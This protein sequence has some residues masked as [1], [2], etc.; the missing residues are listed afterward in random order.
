MIWSNHVCCFRQPRRRAS[1]NCE[2]GTIIND[3]GTELTS[4]AILA[5]CSEDQITGTTSNPGK[6]VQNAFIESF[7]GRLQDELLN[8]T[9]FTSLQYAR[10]ALEDRQRENFNTPPLLVGQGGVGV[11]TLRLQPLHFAVILSAATLD[12]LAQCRHLDL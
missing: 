3:N 1:E 2:P 11:I 9:L 6:P 8:E 5:L 10:F 12:Q 7:N 4:N